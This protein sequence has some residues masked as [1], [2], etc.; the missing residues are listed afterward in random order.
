MHQKT[1]GKQRDWC[2]ASQ[3]VSPHFPWTYIQTVLVDLTGASEQLP[4]QEI[5]VVFKERQVKVP[6]EFHM[7]VLHSQF[8]GRIPMDHL[9]GRTTKPG[10]GHIHR[11]SRDERA[12]GCTVNNRPM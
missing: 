4:P 1:L 2:E 6:E 5:P 10:Q 9:Q 8:L 7:L 12:V 3:A 11:P